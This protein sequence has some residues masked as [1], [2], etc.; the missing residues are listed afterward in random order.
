MMEGYKELRRLDLQLFAEDG[1]A[2]PA[3]LPG[4]LPEATPEEPLLSKEELWEASSFLRQA[5][6]P[7]PEGS[8]NLA[9]PEREEE[10][11]P[12][13]PQESKKPAEEEPKAESTKPENTEEPP[14]FK[15]SDDEEVTA[16]Q[17]REWK[18]GYMLQA[19]YTKK[20]QALAEE[21]RQFEAEK[22]KF[23][24]QVTQNA[25]SL[26]KQMELDPIGTLDK[27]REYYESQGIYEPKD[28]ATLKLE[29][30]KRQLEEEKQR[31]EQE[32]HLRYQ[33]EIYNRIESQ[34]SNLAKKYGAEFNRDEVIDFMRQN[35]IFDAEKA[36]KAMH[37]DTLAESLQKQ[38][39]D[40][41]R[42]IKEAEK[43]A[44]S[45]YVK[46]KTTKQA[47]PLPVGAGNTGSPPVKINPPKTFEDAKKAALARFDQL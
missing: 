27:L 12:E 22:A 2:A 46:T 21:R 3:E 18:K 6:R 33:Q 45:K 15:L 39:D 30:E 28:E 23:D 41:K 29:M 8:D 7:E 4:D 40:L 10:V 5:T 19:D 35:N 16:E 24:P 9:E 14:K 34:L 38:I 36:W 11:V 44:V 42:Q 17:I 43:N 37:H 32:K 26:W 31:L 47:T 20:T 1:G 13:E 25:V